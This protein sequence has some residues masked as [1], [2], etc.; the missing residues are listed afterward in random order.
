MSEVNTDKTDQKITM[1]YLGV[2][3][4]LSDA[5]DGFR[6]LFD[7]K[8]GV[9]EPHATL[10]APFPAHLMCDELDKHFAH[11]IAQFKKQV[12]IAS[13]YYI[14]PQGY[15]FYTFDTASAQI[16]SEL[17]DR[18]HQHSSLESYRERGR[19]F[20]PHI[21]IGKFDGEKGIPWLVRS[22]LPEICERSEIA[23]DH[24]RLYGILAEP[25]KRV[26]VKD[27]LLSA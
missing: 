22:T 10:V 21:T 16:M 26:H 14:T 23:F 3:V 25:K 18:L 12:I 8:Y 20:L 19:P 4:M 24:V 13:D 7:P 2:P 6:N 15:I 17:Y 11:V 1:Y 5:L 9:N 27:Y